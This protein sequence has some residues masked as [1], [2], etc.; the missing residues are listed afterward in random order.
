MLGV[1][2]Y[3]RDLYPCARVASGEFPDR[4]PALWTAL[5]LAVNP[6]S[7]AELVARVLVG[8]SDWLEQEA[9][10]QS[11]QCKSGQVRAN[12]CGCKRSEVSN[13]DN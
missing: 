2:G 6:A 5:D 11:A 9:D 13:S 3:T 4:G 10:G 12:S 1:N 7:N 8:L